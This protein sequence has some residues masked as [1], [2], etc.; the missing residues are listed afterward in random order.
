M[1]N[2]LFLANILFFIILSMY[3]LEFAEKWTPI[4]FAYILHDLKMADH[5]FKSLTV[6]K[7]KLLPWKHM[8]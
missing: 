3:A 1:E 8:L 7:V 4:S 5:T 2:M 6:A